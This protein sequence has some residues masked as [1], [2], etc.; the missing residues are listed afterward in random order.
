MSKEEEWK[1]LNVPGDLA[2]EVN[3]GQVLNLTKSLIN[4]AEHLFRLLA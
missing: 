2:T 1:I 3:I 4:G